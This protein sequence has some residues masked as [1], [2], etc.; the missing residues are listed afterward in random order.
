M[1]NGISLVG[2]QFRIVV[3]FVR[4]QGFFGFFYIKEGGVFYEGVRFFFWLGFYGGNF[5]FCIEEGVKF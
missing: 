2:S 5:D 1:L 4:Y 3:F